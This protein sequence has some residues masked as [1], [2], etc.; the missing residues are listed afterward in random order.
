MSMD[1]GSQQ[2]SL[3]YQAPGNSAEINRR[4]VGV[5][6]V[7]I[8]SGGLLS[9]V[10]A[11]HASL[12]PLVCEIGDGTHQVRVETTTA[13]S[14][15]V[16]SATPYVVL[17]WA[18]TGTTSDYME[19][20][21]VS[22]ANVQANDLVVGKC[23]FAAGALSGFDYGDSAYPRTVPNVQDLWLKVIPKGAGSLKALVLPGWHQ[24]HTGS[25]RVAMQETDAL[26]PPTA[27]SK[28]YLVYLNTETGMVAIDS[29]GSEAASPSAPDYAGRLVLAEITLSST[30]TE[31]TESKIKDVRPF[32]T[33]GR[34][35]VDGTTIE[36]GSDGKLKTADP[37]YF[38]AQT[39]TD[40]ASGQSSWTKC[41]FD[42]PTK[43]FGISESDGVITLPA[44]RLY[45]I[46]YVVRFFQLT[47]SPTV[48]ARLHVLSGDISWVCRMIP[49]MC[50]GKL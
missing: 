10:D 17:R 35:S 42:T 12:A 39:G 30:D 13:V 21:A 24:S 31:I 43:Q 2:I 4:F 38:V 9:V 28:V 8:Y 46:S 22:S 44:G 50:P 23:S 27:N 45:S 34:V 32:L 29:T 20:L 6:P 1:V 48:Q 47:S 40:Q 3:K 5:R 25:V 26:V 49:T 16:G 33:P 14:I 11:T 15:V 41:T 19:I 37:Y 36:A 7:G 18:Y